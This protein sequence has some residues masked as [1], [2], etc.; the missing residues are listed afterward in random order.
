MALAMQVLVSPSFAAD[1]KSAKGKEAVP[2]AVHNLSEWH[3]G[4]VLFGSKPS[5]AELKGKVVVLECWGVHCP[6]CIAS[7][8]HLAELD[9]KLRD[10]G[11]CIIGAESQGSTKEA[12]KP[13]LDAAKVHY[14]ITAGANGP[15]SFSS[16]PRCFI[17]DGQGT[18]VY[19]GYPAGPGFEK[20]IKDSMNKVKSSA[21]TA[22]PSTSTSTS[23]SVAAAPLVPT[24]VWT[25]SEGHEIRAAVSKVDATSVTFLMP[26]AKEV[27]YPLDKLSE[28]S[29][30]SL[31]LV[32]Q[33]K[34]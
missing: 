26:N 9:K 18:L 14:P 31:S 8:P 24:R 3:F 30:T 10:K 34:N 1:G 32:T 25:N 29:R 16:I 2:A 22:T 28:D 13:L 5:D 17:F 11:L 15:I 7:L 21:A 4:E 6:P 20:T 27:V 33:S 23:P 12:I 19:D